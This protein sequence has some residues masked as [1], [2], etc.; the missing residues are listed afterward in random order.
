MA[1]TR[2]P[3]DRKYR[4]RAEAFTQRALQELGDELKAVVLY[5]SV[6]R[7]EARPGSDIDLYILVSDRERVDDRIDAVAWDQDLKVENEEGYLQTH[8]VS[9]DDAQRRA[10]EPNAF[11]LEVARDGIALHDDGTF[12][13]LRKR[14]LMTGPDFRRFAEDD[15]RKAE[16]MLRHARGSH[17]LGHWSSAADR[18]YY[19]MHHSA[20][21][22]LWGRP[23]RMPHSHRGV[24]TQFAQHLIRPGLARPAFSDYLKQGWKLRLDATYESRVEV[25]ESMAGEAMRRAE[26]FL[27]WA[28]GLVGPAEHPG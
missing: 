1:R 18:A 4:K 3:V 28:K 24:E 27:E 7:G 9:A 20:K 22:A 12:A 15:L 10:C 2:A 16:E 14:V 26:E 23:D 25:T 13:D 17:G 21:A 6:A 5:G 11:L 8:A 19:V